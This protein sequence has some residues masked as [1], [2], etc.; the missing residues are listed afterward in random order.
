MALANQTLYRKIPLTV[1]QPCPQTMSIWTGA[2]GAMVVV[3]WNDQL[4]FVPGQPE[5]T[6]SLTTLAGQMLP[7]SIAKYVSGPADAL[8]FMQ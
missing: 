2:G 6:T 1:G 4:N 7:L 5:I 3:L 8:G